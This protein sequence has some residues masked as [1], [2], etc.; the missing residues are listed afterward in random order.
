[1]RVVSC[2][3]GDLAIAWIFIIFYNPVER[4]SCVFFLPCS[5]IILSLTASRTLS[6]TASRTR[7]LPRE[8]CTVELEPKGRRR[9]SSHLT[10]F[11][12]SNVF[13]FGQAEIGDGTPEVRTLEASGC[14]CVSICVC[15]SVVFF[16]VPSPLLTWSHS[17]QLTQL[18]KHHV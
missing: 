13:S 18:P 1:M 12:F 3:A 8:L 6:L 14:S 4:R 7:C 5:S 9:S 15:E 17:C 11:L 10:P 2:Y 16:S